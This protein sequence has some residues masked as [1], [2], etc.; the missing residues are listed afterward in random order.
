MNDTE[1]DQLLTHHR[2]DA[3]ID[4]A[5]L[6]TARTRVLAA[7]GLSVAGLPDTDLSVA[8]LSVAGLPAAAESPQLAATSE[9]RKGKRWGIAMV[10][11]AV[12]L[13]LAGAFLLIPSSVPGVAE[14]SAATVLRQAAAASRSDPVI[15]P[16]QFLL[17]ETRAWF[18]GISQGSE[19]IAGIEMTETLTQVWRP[20]SWSDTWTMR[21]QQTGNRRWFVTPAV[22]LP[23]DTTPHTFTGPCGSYGDYATGCERVGTWEFPTPDFMAGLPRDPQ[24]LLDR[25]EKDLR[26]S[27]YNNDDRFDQVIRML[28]TGLAPSDLRSALYRMLALIDGVEIT[29]SLANLD[30]R[31]GTAI[32]LVD[33]SGGFR[34]DIIIDPSSGEFIGERVV[35]LRALAGIPANAVLGSTSVTMVVVPEAGVVPTR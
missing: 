29:E 2:D 21:E 23:I 26:D 35:Q 19:E 24:G 10:A 18:T 1:L 31:E 32:G 27:G 12:V 5:A 16:G 9:P 22:Q 7:A 33:P 28:R 15:P 8:G 11:A 4:D 14:A 17:I 20:A 3:D 25:L 6:A 30:G 34:R 13:L